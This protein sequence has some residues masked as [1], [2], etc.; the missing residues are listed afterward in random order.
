MSSSRSI[1]VLGIHRSGTSAL[2]GALQ[3]LGVDMGTMGR[4]E[5]SSPD[6]NPVGQYEDEEGVILLNGTVGNWR[7]P[8]KLLYNHEAN[9]AFFEYVKRREAASPLWGFKDP[10][11]CFYWNMMWNMPEA[12]AVVY[13]IRDPDKIAAS[14]ME[15]DKFPPFVASMLVS[16]YWLGLYS[17]IALTVKKGIP[18]HGVQYPQLLKKP[19]TTLALMCET[20]GLDP[21]DEQMRDAAAHIDPTLS[22]HGDI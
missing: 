4:P 20:I 17:A 16:E 5:I 3:H 19:Y 2:A 1:W 13:T 11:L 7:I 18:V 9:D 22:H 15:R 21:T 12:P 8:Q 10:R 6:S 14:I